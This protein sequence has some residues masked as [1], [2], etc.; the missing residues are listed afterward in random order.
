MF[1]AAMNQNVHFNMDGIAQ[2]PGQ[3]SQPQMTSLDQ[4]SSQWQMQDQGAFLRQVA[5]APKVVEEGP[6]SMTYLSQGDRNGQQVPNL[7][8]QNFGPGFYTAIP[9]EASAADSASWNHQQ[10]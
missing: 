5:V 1:A 2:V 4:V 9:G 3:P 10:R 8:N 6:G 7:N